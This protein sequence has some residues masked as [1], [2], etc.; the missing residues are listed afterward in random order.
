MSI[1]VRLWNSF[2]PHRNSLIKIGKVQQLYTTSIAT[3]HSFLY[4][5][6]KKK[7]S[8]NSL[9]QVAP[10]EVLPLLQTIYQNDTKETWR[11]YLELYHKNQLHL[12]SPLQHSKVLKNFSFEKTFDEKQ[13][14]ILKNQVFFI[15]NKMKSIGI[16]PDVNDFTH[17]LNTFSL[18]GS[19]KICDN[20][21]EEMIK[22]KIQ[23]TTYMYNSY[24]TSCWRMIKSRKGK[25]EGFRRAQRILI[26]LRSSGKKPNI[27]TNC[28][29]ARLFLASNDLGSAQGLLEMTFSQNN[30][31][32]ELTKQEILR[33]KSMIIHTFNY[34]MNAHGNAGDLLMMDRCFRLFIETE[35]SPHIY[36]FNTLV[37]NSSRMDMDKAKNYIE[38]MFH[39]FN[40]NPTHQIF[41]YILFNLYDKGLTK[42]A[43][44]FLKVMEDEF[45]SPPSELM[46][47]K[48]YKS[49]LRKKRYVEAKEFADQWNDVINLSRDD[50]L[51]VRQN[52]DLS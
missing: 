22:R 48:I 10:K 32:K 52:V 23:P 16:E 11:L 19:P 35:L 46:L 9:R 38:Q 13:R 43:V 26:S 3:H 21:W 39:E 12:L 29:L 47:V 42:K 5:P 34:L 45:K 2:K 8:S 31:S 6:P 51:P 30:L 15:F 40:L 27:I 50:S 25:E 17:M 28:L 44:E 33:S 4:D 7:D 14:Y 41:S 24:I 49:M 36:L 37:R 20:L 18:I 1:A